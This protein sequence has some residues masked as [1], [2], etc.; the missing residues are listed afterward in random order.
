LKLWKFLRNRHCATTSNQT[1]RLNGRRNKIENTFPSCEVLDVRETE[2]TDVVEH[3]VA[4]RIS[5]APFIIRHISRR[6]KIVIKRRRRPIT[7]Q[8]R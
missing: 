7:T 2:A 4:R 8:A 5:V 1:K 3:G 6:L